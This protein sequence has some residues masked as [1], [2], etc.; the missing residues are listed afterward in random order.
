MSRG[1][2]APEANTVARRERSQGLWPLSVEPGESFKWGAIKRR[3]AYNPDGTEDSTA[4]QEDA[5][6]AY[7]EQHK[8]GRI[9][10]EYTDIASAYDEKAKRPE[11]ENAL[12]DLR[13]KRINGIIVWKLD[14]LTRRRN[15]MRRILTLLEDCG[16]RLVSVVEGI[17]TADPNKRQITELVLNVY[18][19]IAQGESEAESERVKLMHLDRARRGLVQ[20]GGSRPY[21]FTDNRRSALVDKEVKVLHEAGRRVL[22]NEAPHAIARDL[23]NRKVPTVKGGTHWH[24]EVLI[25]ILVNPR[26]VA[27]REYEGTVYNVEGAASVFDVETWERIRAKLAPPGGRKASGIIPTRVDGRFL[28][29]YAQCGDCSHPLRASSKQRR[30]TRSRDPNEFSYQCR[31]RYDGGPR[32]GACGRV[33]ITGTFADSEV[34]RQVVAWLSDHENI[35][36]LLLR[37]ADPA[38]VEKIHTRVAELTEYKHD[39]YRA[40]APTQA[41]IAKGIPK[42]PLEDYQERVTELEAERRA[43]LQRLAVTRE[44]E[45]LAALLEVPDVAAEWDAQPIRWRRTILKLVTASIVV[46]PRGKSEPGVIPIRRKFDPTRITVTFAA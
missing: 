11:F 10:A 24:P 37:S 7:V 39:L 13:A 23:S 8:E 20:P 5:I 44:D 32:A 16:G 35:E 34:T 2:A 40:L 46:E 33:W 43:Q 28:S 9:V 18:M 41:E 29:G 31:R 12:D 6:Y 38:E 19:S 3:S 15:Q 30:G 25:G 42:M 17:D 26:M 14:R 1:Y 27:Q 21:G 22:N 36:R 4:R 45:K